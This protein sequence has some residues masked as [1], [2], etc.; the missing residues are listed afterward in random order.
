VRAFDDNTVNNDIAGRI[1]D[2]GGALTLAHQS[3]C[4]FAVVGIL[5]R[6]GADI[7]ADNC[8]QQLRDNRSLSGRWRVCGQRG[9]GH[10]RGGTQH[11]RQSQGSINP[12][13]ATP[14]RTEALRDMAKFPLLTAGSLTFEILRAGRR[15]PK[16]GHPPCYRS[17]STSIVP[18]RT[19]AFI[20]A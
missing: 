3:G 18:A 7:D 19:A 14:M 4:A 1:D 8:R 10:G 15:G 11:H 16:F 6:R 13:L 17:N 9:R 2:K 20:A 5:L 12:K